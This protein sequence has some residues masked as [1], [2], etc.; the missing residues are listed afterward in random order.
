MFCDCNDLWLCHLQKVHLQ[1]CWTKTEQGPKTIYKTLQPTLRLQSTP[2]P[3]MYPRMYTHTFYAAR[4]QTKCR[5]K[6][7]KCSSGK[8]KGTWKA[9]RK[10]YMFDSQGSKIWRIFV[11]SHSVLMQKQLETIYMETSQYFETCL[12]WVFLVTSALGRKYT[13]LTE[14]ECAFL[15]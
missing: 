1:R 7:N 13:K 4:I 2:Y 8:A 3:G 15:D 12:C 14:R 10:F 11:C 5:W 9:L 6:V